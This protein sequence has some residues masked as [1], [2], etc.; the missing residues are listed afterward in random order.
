[1]ASPSDDC[2]VARQT[3]AT[4]LH[5][6]DT[7]PVVKPPGLPGGPGYG[8]SRNATIDQTGGVLSRLGYQ[9]TVV[10]IEPNLA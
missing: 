3:R 7:V 6:G 5:Q 9:E 4:G 10:A 1:M 8:D 2:D